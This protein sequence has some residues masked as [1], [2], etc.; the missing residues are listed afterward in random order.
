MKKLPRILSTLEKA[1]EINFS[2]RHYGTIAEIG[3]GQEVARW[4]FQAGGAAG[5][6][7]K[8]MSAYDMTFSNAIYGKSGRFVSRERLKEMLN[9]EYRLL[10]ERLGA[11]RGD[12]SRFFVF[13]DTVTARSHKHAADEIGRAH[14]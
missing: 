6:I 7:A 3:A 11:E 8:S 12:H 2:H 1:Q 13:A 9:Y 4:F 14:V 5:T 10:I